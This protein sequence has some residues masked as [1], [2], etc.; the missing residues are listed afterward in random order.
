M[1]RI[2][3]IEGEQRKFLMEVLKNLNCPSLRSFSQFGFEVPYPTLKNYF[4][5]K[6]TLPEEFFNELVSFS[7]VDVKNFEYSVLKENWG[8]VK[9]GKKRIS[10]P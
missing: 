1:F 6:R 4:S 3:F 7:K 9:G 8:Q 10:K 5:E 2:K